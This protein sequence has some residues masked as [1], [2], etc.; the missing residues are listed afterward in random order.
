LHWKAFL[1]KIVHKIELRLQA[2]R[3]SR[4]RS[5]PWQPRQPTTLRTEE[6]CRL[7]AD[8]LDEK[9]LQQRPDEVLCTR[10]GAELTRRHLSC[11][12]PDQWLNDEVVNCYMKLLQECSEGQIWC[13]NT[14]FWNK[15]EA[16]GHA[17]V[18]RW[19][20]RAA[21]NVAELRAILVPLHLEGCHWSLAMVHI[22][23]RTISYFD[24]LSLPVPS[25]LGQRLTEFMAAEVASFPGRRLDLQVDNRLPQQENSS[26]CGI[27]MLVYAERLVMDLPIG[28][29]TFMSGIEEKRLSIALAIL[30]GRLSLTSREQRQQ[31]TSCTGAQPQLQRAF[32][33]VAPT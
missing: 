1:K 24:S 7:L 19:T 14:F 30:E 20:R 29:D 16:G 32:C 9:L 13:A 22:P 18:Q 28:L 21:V 33:L 11:L 25:L 5:L 3:C 17:A 12:L 15:L 10:F 6:Q 26:D 27:F 23:R 31:D 8:G 4:S 2:P